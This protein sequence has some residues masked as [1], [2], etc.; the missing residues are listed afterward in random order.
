MRRVGGWLGCDER[1]DGGMSTSQH[2]PL[3]LYLSRI[4]MVCF[5]H[6]ALTKCERAH[7]PA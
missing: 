3:A 5:E 6:H 4:E 7:G 1:R 2:L